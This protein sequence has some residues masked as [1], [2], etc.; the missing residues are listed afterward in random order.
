MTSYSDDLALEIPMLT[1]KS[2]QRL[3]QVGGLYKGLTVGILRG[4]ESRGTPYT[5]KKHLQAI[6]VQV[7][8][9]L[10]FSTCFVIW[11]ARLAQV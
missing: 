5:L 6:E 7:D 11:N 1:Q 10:R 4:L 3:L 8:H 9:I 2:L